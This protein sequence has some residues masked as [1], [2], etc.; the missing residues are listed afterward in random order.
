MDAVTHPAAI[1]A[2][3]TPHAADAPDA[4]DAPDA[5]DVAV[6]A[7]E[8]LEAEL[9]AHAAWEAT[10]A[11]RM[12]AVLAEWDRRRGWDS[13]GCASA[14]QWL[15]WQCGL[16]YVAASE[17]LRVAR[18]LE[19]LPF[20]RAG[21]AEATLS[22]SKVR[23]LTRVATPATDQA[24]GELAMSS[25]ASMVARLV[26]SL[27]RRTP[28]D[29]LSQ[30]ERRGFAWH[31]DDSDGSVVIT[32]R[33]PGDDG[34]AVV[35]AVEAATTPTAGVP[36]AQAR[37]DALVGLVTGVGADDVVRP[38]V[39][40]HVEADKVGIDGGPAVAPEIAE[41]CACDGPVSTVVDTTHGAFVVRKDPPVSRTQRRALALRH[42]TCQFPGCGNDGR[43]DAHH[44][45]E[46]HLG[47]AT[48]L[49][50]LVRLCRFHHRLVH[51]LR[52]RVTLHADRRVEVAF[53]AGNPVERPIPFAPFAAPT[54]HDPSWI[55]STW[56][57]DRLQLN[58]IHL[59]IDELERRATP[60]ADRPAANGPS[61]PRETRNEVGR[62]HPSSDSTRHPS[63]PV[64]GEGAR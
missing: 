29:V 4:P 45:V 34:M 47:G 62:D 35:R 48:K 8:R 33:L 6:M 23:E 58:W 15:S 17:R 11:A 1:D 12:L 9:V 24:L 61:F 27:R 36:L 32:L 26:R 54:P 22:Y 57:G 13:W 19:Q 3:P 46:R 18:A 37:A 39:V 55:S 60:P 63:D 56:D 59:V 14:Q 10:G 64:A 50:N 40:I 51:V 28:R 30:L 41:F 5:G 49:H 52:L 21:L 38:E 25:T 31:T 20:I 42:R 53:P 43:F 16:G 7:T 44:V 2:T